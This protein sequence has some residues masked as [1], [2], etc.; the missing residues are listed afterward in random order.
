MAEDDDGDDDDGFIT[1]NRGVNGKGNISDE[2]K[3]KIIYILLQKYNPENKKMSHG[4]IK[5]T[6]ETFEVHRFTVP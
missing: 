3:H 5:D 4:A 6:V 1:P 2:V